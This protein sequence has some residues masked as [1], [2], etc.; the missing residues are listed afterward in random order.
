MFSCIDPEERIP[1][2]HPLRKIRALVR[3]VPGELDQD[4]A[5]T[6]SLDGTLIE[7]WASHKSFRPKGSSD[8]ND[9]ES[10]CGQKRRNGTRQSSSS[11][12]LVY[13]GDAQEIDAT[14]MAFVPVRRHH[15]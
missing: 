13:D 9:G 7:A 10:F 4:F 11:T 6:C 12:L 1:L 3:D 14:R 2:Q 8:D 5:Q 15:A